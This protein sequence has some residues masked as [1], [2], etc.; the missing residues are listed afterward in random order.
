M[1]RNYDNWEKLV[2]AVLKREEFRR[3]AHCESFSTSISTDLSARSSFDF[4]V[5]HDSRN[6]KESSDQVP[7]SWESIFESCN[8]KAIPFEEIKLATQNFQQDMLLGGG[9]FG[10]VFKGW[11]HEHLLTAVKPGSGVAVAIKKLNK[12]ELLSSKIQKFFLVLDFVLI[13]YSFEEGQKFLVYEFMPNGSLD[14]H[15]FTRGHQLLSWEK[16]VEVATAAARGLLFFHDLAIIV[17]HASVKSSSILLDDELNAKLSDLDLTT[18]LR[19]DPLSTPVRN[20]Y[21]APEYIASGTGRLTMKSDVY[22]FGII[23]LELLTGLRVFDENRP[24]KEQNLIVWATR[25]SNNRK[26]L[27]QIVDSR[28]E[29]KYPHDEAYKFGKLAL[30]CLSLD[31]KLRPTMAEVTDILEKFSSPLSVG[32]HYCQ[33]STEHSTG[34]DRQTD[35]AGSS[36]WLVLQPR[37]IDRQTDQAGSSNWL[38]LQPRGIDRQTDQAGSSN[39]LVLQPRGIDRQTDQAGSSNW[40]VLQPRGIDRQTDQAG[41]SNWLVLQPRGIDRQTDQAGSSNWLVL[42]PRG[43]DRQTDQAGSSNWLVLQPRGIDRQTDQAGSSN[44]LVLQPRGIDRQTDQ[45]GSSNWLVLQPKGALKNGPKK[46]PTVK[47]VRFV[48]DA[49]AESTVEAGY[50]SLSHYDPLYGLIFNTI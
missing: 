5:P 23:L 33:N 16:R 9:R 29:R 46:K 47:K 31:P 48:D 40:L 38:V 39:W 22:S 7:S 12:E 4:D 32:P 20:D 18:T 10:S 25:Y 21:A 28:L 43:I 26:K 13:G 3:L 6:S 50:R 2:A 44:W 41:S 1:S 19:L 45:A 30:Q 34:I 17:T 14:N 15:L 35:Q 24:M 36:N 37:G 27:L 49:L 8:I 11:I 42:Q